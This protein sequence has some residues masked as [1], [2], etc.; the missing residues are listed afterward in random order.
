MRTYTVAKQDPSTDGSEVVTGECCGGCKKTIKAPFAR[1]EWRVANCGAVICERVVH[2][3][4]AVV[5]ANSTNYDEYMPV[6]SE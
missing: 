3:T 4:S 6:S 2:S 5:A 1:F